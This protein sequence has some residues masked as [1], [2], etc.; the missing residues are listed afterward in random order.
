MALVGD[1]SPV[2]A[3]S[4]DPLAVCRGVRVGDEAPAVKMELDLPPVAVNELM[5][6]RVGAPPIKPSL[7]GA[8]ELDPKKKVAYKRFADM[9]EKEAFRASM[10][11]GLKAEWTK[12]YGADKAAVMEAQFKDLADNHLGRNGAVIFGALLNTESFKVLIERYGDVLASSGSESLLHSYVNLGNHPDFLADR[13][14]NA[15]FLHPLLV[16]L[17]S[18]RVGG[19]IRIVDAR[20]KDA[21]PMSVLAQ[22]NMLHIDNTPFNDEFKMILTWERGKPSG[23][24][25]QNFVFVPGTHHG[26]RDCFYDADRGV[27]ST[28]NASIFTDRRSIGDMLDFQRRVRGVSEPVIVEA[29]HATKPLTTVFQAGALV[30]HRYRTAEGCARSCMI[31]AFHRAKDNPGQ[32]VAPEHLEG[33]AEPGSLYSFLLGRHTGEEA[34]GAFLSALARESGSML[35]VFD[36]LTEPEDRGAAGP[37]G[38]DEAEEASVVADLGA[39]AVAEDGADDK[40]ELVRMEERVLSKAEME[41]WIAASTDADT[42]EDKKVKA[43]VVVLGE[44]LAGDA[45]TDRLSL[46]MGYDKH[47]PLDLP[48]YADAH[49]EIRKWARNQIREMKSEELTARLAD[50][51]GDIVQ[52]SQ[53]HLIGAKDLQ[54]LAYTLADMADAKRTDG[55]AI[56][57][58]KGE[59]IS[60]EDAYRSIA[61]LLRDLGESITRCEDRQAFLSTSL[62]LF[63]ACD[64]LMRFEPDPDPS[65]RGIGEALLKNYVSTMVLVHTQIAQERGVL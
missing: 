36:A 2:L 17:V 54:A 34:D 29:T 30:H 3:G 33:V 65:I 51:E 25:G 26:S 15:A 19:P 60:R 39:D 49:E 23:P 48:L 57:L 38:G 43:E 24:K 52:P 53:D 63:W 56:V 5:H 45:K 18:Y 10:L 20:G 28:E 46:I 41:A 6:E 50:W 4:G 62:F 11:T 47:G 37:G 35:E 7:V 42:I 12:L 44:E 9:A 58:R 21:K 22:D 27:W 13:R 16:A 32:L 8:D 55:D 14:F 40:T 61:Q 59:K 1:R 31:V 64:T